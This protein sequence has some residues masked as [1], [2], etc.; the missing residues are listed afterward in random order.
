[1][2][3]LDS[4]TFEELSFSLFGK[5]I[6]NIHRLYLLGE[7]NDG[8]RKCRCSRVKGC[9]AFVLELNLGD[10]FGSGTYGSLILV[11]FSRF[12]FSYREI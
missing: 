2:E 7:P 4:F 10:C 3:S 6:V 11:L 5:R 12:S 8:K 1:M 9:V